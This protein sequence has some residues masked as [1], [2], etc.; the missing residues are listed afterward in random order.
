[1]LVQKQD[2]ISSQAESITEDKDKNRI[3]KKLK[4]SENNKKIISHNHKSDSRVK[5]KQRKGLNTMKHPLTRCIY[6]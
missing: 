1:M 6:Q 5:L 4:L 3:T 2:K